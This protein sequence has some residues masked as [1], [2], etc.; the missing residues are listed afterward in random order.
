MSDRTWIT[1]D[2]TTHIYLAD[3]IAGESNGALIPVVSRETLQR[4]VDDVA[5]DWNL[6]WDDRGAVL[7]HTRPD[8]DPGAV[9]LA[10]VDT[11][12]FLMDAGW[13]WMEADPPLVHNGDEELVTACC[14]SDLVV[15]VQRPDLLDYVVDRIGEDGI[16]VA[17]FHRVT[18]CGG[19]TV[20]EANCR[21]CGTPYDLPIDLN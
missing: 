3:R 7:S 18:A 1:G 17:T 9:R 12:R 8:S 21:A 20:V 2:W 14:G 4:I 13:C 5:P 15:V 11:Q 10:P 19:S 6:T 16:V